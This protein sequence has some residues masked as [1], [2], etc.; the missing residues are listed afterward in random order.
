MFVDL[1][2][3]CL[4]VCRQTQLMD[5]ISVGK[6]GEDLACKYLFKKGY[7]IIDRNYRLK[8]GEIDIIAI[9][10][11]KTL[12]FIEVKTL[13]SGNAAINS[14]D[15][16]FAGLMPEDN[17]TSSK[18]QKLSKTCELFAGKNPQLIKEG[19]GWRID[20]VAILLNEKNEAEFKHYENISL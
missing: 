20:L 17:L 10:R 7:R 12:V 19:K 13:K 1:Q 2:L 15:E 18:L 8:I 6:L 9:S 5:H 14:A 11:D 16:Q 4:N 3:N